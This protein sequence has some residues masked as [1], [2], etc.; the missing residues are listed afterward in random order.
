M[1][2]IEDST[3]KSLVERALRRCECQNPECRHHRAGTRCTRGLRG[4]DWYVVVREPN[5]GEKLWNLLAMCPECFRIYGKK[6]P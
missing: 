5:A 1:T 2:V 4:E 3:R 6:A